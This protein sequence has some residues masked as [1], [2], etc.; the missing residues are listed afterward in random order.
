MDIISP[1]LTHGGKKGDVAYGTLTS[2]D[3]SP[4][5]FGLLYTGS[6]DG[7]IYRST[8]AG[9][10]WTRLDESLP[11]NLWV[12]TVIAGKHD[13]NV[14]YATLNGYR[15]DDFAAYVY[16]SEDMGS[17]WQ[18]VGSDLPNEA[19]NVILEDP[20]NENLL[21]VGTDHGLYVS[22]DKGASFVAMHNGLPA[23]AVHSL[24]IQEQEKDLVVGTHGRS[25]YRA[26]IGLLQTAAVAEPGITLIAPNRM[27]YSS[28][29]GRQNFNFK[30]VE[31]ELSFQVF[32]PGEDAGAKL[33]IKSSDGTT[34]YT[35]N[36]ALQGGVNTIAYDMS[37]DGSFAKTMEEALNKDRKPD[38][39]PVTIKAAKN[40]KYYL[41]PGKYEAILEVEGTQAKAKMT[42]K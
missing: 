30:V 12:T 2:I 24:A 14:V 37:F 8:D 32:L 9:T 4:L 26:N 20:T 6:D 13:K 3:E 27:R 23:V 1:D 38:A 10:N 35:K 40:G 19:V 18:K 28:R 31:P 15:N 36:V 33:M 7:M 25:L 5:Q 39:K 22:M 29:Y 16:R 17:T 42:V 34:V 21:F 11:Q 41:R